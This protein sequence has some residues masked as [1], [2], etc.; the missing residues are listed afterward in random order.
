[1]GV[2]NKR[3]DLN[4]ILVIDKPLGWSSA[5]VC[6]VI[7][8]MTG[9]A[10][11]GHAGT[12]DPLATGVLVVCLGRATKLVEGIMGTTKAYRAE[13][14]LSAFT[15]TDDRE[16]ERTEVDVATPP[17]LE[18]IRS[19]LAS[20]FTGEIRQRPPAFSAVKIEG[21]RAY[22]LARAGGAPAPEPKTV[23]IHA[24]EVRGY[25]WPMLMLEIECSKG[26]Y[27]RSI[28][29]DLGRVLGTGGTLASLVRTRV[30]EFT[31]DRAL[32][33]DDLP[34]PITPEGLLQR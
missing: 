21:Q 13:V 16:G 3:P 19:A 8:R 6:R 5:K 30:G 18:A 4:G 14:D 31:L 26:T 10:K 34:E 22:R 17:T 12:L 28:A 2:R 23:T 29:R 20:G 33:P 9:G 24:I 1:M 27:I 15:T 7:R 25:D 11:V 32:A